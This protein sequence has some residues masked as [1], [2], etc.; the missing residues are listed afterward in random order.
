MLANLSPGQLFNSMSSAIDVQEKFFDAL[1][2]LK[3]H[4]FLVLLTVFVGRLAY[5]RYGTSLRSV[6]GP[7]V[8][9]FTRLWKLRQMFRGDM[10]L[11]DIALHRKYGFTAGY[12]V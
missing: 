10:H 12:K 3:A 8:A 7:F 2:F 1:H 5:K 4:P 9:S 6:P 11:T